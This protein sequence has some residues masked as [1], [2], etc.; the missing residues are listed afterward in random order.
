MATAIPR[1]TGF[2]QDCWDAGTI[3]HTQHNSL[4]LS[5]L[6][7]LQGIYVVQYLAVHPY[8]QMVYLLFIYFYL[9]FIYFTYLLFVG[10]V[11][12]IPNS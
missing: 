8:I 4:V 3:Y 1:H 6:F 12:I 9:L 7:I 5:M 10:F 2:E 11:K